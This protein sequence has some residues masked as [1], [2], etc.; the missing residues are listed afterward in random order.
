[1]ESVIFL[2][3]TEDLITDRREEGHVIKAMK[4]ETQEP[5]RMQQTKA[6]NSKDW[7]FPERIERSLLLFLS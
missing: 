5:N 7:L 2:C 4:T 1:M 3:D 6:K